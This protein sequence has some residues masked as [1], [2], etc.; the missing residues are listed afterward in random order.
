MH[1][2]NIAFALLHALLL[3]AE[4]TEE[5]LHQSPIEESSVFIHPRNL[6]ISEVAYFTK[7]MLSSSY[8]TLFLVEVYEHFK[9]VAWFYVLWY[10]T[11]GQ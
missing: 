4:G 3:L 10:I 8:G 7:R 5:V 9:F 1:V 2:H 11:F 6:Q